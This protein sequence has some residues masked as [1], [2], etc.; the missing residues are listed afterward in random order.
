[1]QIIFKVKSQ[2]FLIWSSFHRGVRMRALDLFLFQHK[3]KDHYLAAPPDSELLRN[4]L[5]IV[6]YYL[7]VFKE[8]NYYIQ[9]IISIYNRKMSRGFVE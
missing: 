6:V 3:G 7:R 2:F 9:L 4:I 8:V 1:M 5:I